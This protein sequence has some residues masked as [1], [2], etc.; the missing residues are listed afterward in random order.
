MQKPIEM[1]QN[2]GQFHHSQE[3]ITVPPL[4]GLRGDPWQWRL[5]DATTG[6]S[7]R[8]R[9]ETPLIRSLRPPRGVWLTL[10]CP[11]FVCQVA[12]AAGTQLVITLPTLLLV[13]VAF[14]GSP[15][16]WVVAGAKLFCQAFL[17]TSSRS[18]LSRLH[19]TCASL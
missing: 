7:C 15:F 14:L 8:L 1:T 13:T 10:V 4:H 2:Q 19:Y 11:T 5:S 9:L 16:I 17:Q 3:A 6:H 18:R 12:K